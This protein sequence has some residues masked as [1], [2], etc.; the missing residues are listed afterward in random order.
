MTEGNVNREGNVTHRLGIMGGT[1]DP[2]HWGHLRVADSIRAQFK[3]D[4]VIFIP[5]QCPPH[6]SISDIAPVEHR[7]A[8]VELAIAENPFFEASR[9]E[10]D[11]NC[12]T[13]AGDTIEAFKKLYGADGELYFITGIDALLTIVD[14][15][16]SR[17]YP[18]LCRFVAAAR[19]G[20]DSRAVEKRIPEEFRPYVII[21]EELAPAI[22][23]TEIRQRVKDHLPIEHLVPDAVRDYILTGGLYRQ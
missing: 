2:I 9:I 6:K 22:S 12:P 7:Y 16:R 13:Y 10:I 23:S 8:M 21:V 3:L 5:S 1:F 20:Y 15:E 11:R 14:Q 18:G 4:K 17:T 19:P